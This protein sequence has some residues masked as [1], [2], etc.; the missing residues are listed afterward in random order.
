MFCPQADSVISFLLIGYMVAE[1]AA[2]SNVQD[3]ICWL[4][5]G[6]QEFYKGITLGEIWHNFCEAHILDASLRLCA[7]IC[8]SACVGEDV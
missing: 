4:L 7:E 3:F 5:I 8:F 2:E 6:L 1:L